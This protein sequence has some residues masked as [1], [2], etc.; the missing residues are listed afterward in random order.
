MKQNLKVMLR[1]NLVALK[2]RR[3]W[4]VLLVAL[5]IFVLAAALSSGGFASIL[6]SDQGRIWTYRFILFL[7]TFVLGV[8]MLPIFTKSARDVAKL[9]SWHYYGDVLV[10]AHTPRPGFLS[11]TRTAFFAQRL[12]RQFCGIMGGAVQ[13]LPAYLYRFSVGDNN[14]VEYTIL[15]AIMPYELP[16]FAR[17]SA[18]AYGIA[19][20]IDDDMTRRIELEGSFGK[21]YTVVVSANAPDDHINALSFLAPDVMDIWER[22]V[23]Q[24]NLLCDGPSLSIITTKDLYSQRALPSLVDSFVSLAPKIQR[25]LGIREM[26][27]G[28]RLFPNQGSWSDGGV[29]TTQLRDL[30]DPS[31]L[32][33]KQKSCGTLTVILLSWASPRLPCYSYH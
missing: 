1:R 7:S 3:Y 22:Q 27:G 33:C 12:Q 15:T 23:G 8:P 11:L 30:P 28:D 31:Q 26:T 20:L 5:E 2:T 29:V 14:P 32:P 21:H 16:R 19:R 24:F 4:L 13:D 17:L 10:N 18:D 9:L 6:H 25:K